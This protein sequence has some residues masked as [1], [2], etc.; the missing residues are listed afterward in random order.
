[1]S[2][3]DW[4]IHHDYEGAPVTL[5]VEHCR[6]IRQAASVWLNVVRTQ[7][8]LADEGKGPR[9][10]GTLKAV[11]EVVQALHSPALAKSCLMG[12]MLYEG[13]PPLP[14][15]PPLVFSAPAY[16]LVENA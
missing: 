13:K 11:E 14:E 15:P 5:T 3:S 4:K 10:A 9:P 7:H 16:H 1:M 12:R 8:K 6:A 2:A